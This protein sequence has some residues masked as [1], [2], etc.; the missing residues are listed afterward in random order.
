MALDV[1]DNC[2]HTLLELTAKLEYA[3]LAL[4]ELASHPDSKSPLTIS[5]ISTRHLIPE[6]YLEQIFTLLRRGGMLQSQRGAKGGYT[7][8]KEPWQV[9]V[10]DVIALVEGDRKS[11][12]LGNAASVEQELV[13]EIWQKANSNFQVALSQYTLHDLCQHRDLRKQENHMYY[14]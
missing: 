10:L 9:T 12:K 8:S 2:S 14:I 1:S 13:Y 3:L 11:K 7:L 6:R 5:E 4:M